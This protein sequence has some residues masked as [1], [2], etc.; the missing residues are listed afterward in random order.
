MKEVILICNYFFEIADICKKI[1]LDL[2][3]SSIIDSNK[4]ENLYSLFS[5]YKNDLLSNKLVRADFVWI[6]FYTSNSMIVQ[7]NYSKHNRQLLEEWEKY[8]QA[9]LSLQEEYNPEEVD[10]KWI[11]SNIIYEDGRAI[12]SDFFTFLR[13]QY[14]LLNQSELMTNPNKF[15]EIGSLFKSEDNNLRDYWKLSRKVQ[16]RLISNK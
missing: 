10:D 9:L 3:P 13:Y 12:T 5:R 16:N 11:E 4:F 2:R 15:T 7:C 8:N 6:L 1:C 14:S